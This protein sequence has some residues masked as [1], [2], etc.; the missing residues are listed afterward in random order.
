MEKNLKSLTALDEAIS[1]NL[2]MN[3]ID[4]RLM[5]PVVMENKETG[6]LETYRIIGDQYVPEAEAMVIFQEKVVEK[7]QKKLELLKQQLIEKD[8]IREIEQKG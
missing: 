4:Q 6:E 8:E 7:E 5:P 3:E 2:K 1:R